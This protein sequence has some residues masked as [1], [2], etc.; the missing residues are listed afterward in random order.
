MGEK[1]EAQKKA[2]QNIWKSLSAWR[3][4]WMLKREKSFK[5]TQKPAARA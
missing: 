5:P 1:T 3:S 2:Q 4:E